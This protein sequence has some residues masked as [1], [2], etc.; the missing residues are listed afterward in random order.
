[1]IENHHKRTLERNMLDFLIGVRDRIL[2]V[3]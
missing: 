2:V 3:I 1:M